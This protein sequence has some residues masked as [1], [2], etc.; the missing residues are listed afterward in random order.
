M[1]GLGNQLFQY[2]LGRHLAIKNN[3]E[4]RL[5]LSSFHYNPD[6][7]FVLN[8]FNINAIEATPNQIPYHKRDVR[9][10][11]FRSRFS[12]YFNTSTP[13]YNEPHF[14]FDENVLKCKSPKYLYGYWQ[15]EKYFESIKDEILNEF[16]FKKPLIENSSL[17]FNKIRST[18]SVAIHV[19][20]GDYK[21]HGRLSLLEDNYYKK[22]FEEILIRVIDPSFFVFSDDIEWCQNHFK[23]GISVNY[24][25]TFNDLIDFELMRLC[26]HHIIANS[27]FSWWAAYLSGFPKATT[28]APLDWFKPNSSYTSKDLYLDSWLTI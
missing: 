6:R 20:R 25:E 1:G 8:A 4:L 7:C 19:R 16:R 10:N 28:I 12:E 5:D 21:N 13:I 24:V 2:A 27:T 17:S 23:F 14:H 3:T 15:S 18:S 9:K 22:A 11:R 26:K